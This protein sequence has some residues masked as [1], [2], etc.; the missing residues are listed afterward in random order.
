MK[1]KELTEINKVVF[2][3]IGNGYLIKYS[4]SEDDKQISGTVTDDSLLNIIEN[5]RNENCMVLRE[6][7]NNVIDND[8]IPFVFS[9]FNAFQFVFIDFEN[10][11]HSKIRFACYFYITKTKNGFVIS[12]IKSQ[13]S[14]LV[15]CKSEEYTGFFRQWRCKKHLKNNLIAFILKEKAKS[16]NAKDDN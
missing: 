12:N 7:F 5:N 15:K 3:K 8:I 16:K 14:S 11:N 10:N 6:N 1:S 9:K 13:L 4:N 2:I